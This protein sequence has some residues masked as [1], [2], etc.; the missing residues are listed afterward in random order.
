MATYIYSLSSSHSLSLSL[1]LSLLFSLSFSLPF[2]RPNFIRFSETQRHCCVSSLSH[3]L[4]PPCL[5]FSL[6]TYSVL[7]FLFFSLFLYP[8]LPLIRDSYYLPTLLT[9]SP[10][11]T[12]CF[13]RKGLLV[14]FFFDFI[15]IYIYFFRFSC[16]FYICFL[17]ITS[18]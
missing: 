16:V 18:V 13:A 5:S 11:V 12:S 10:D 8:H 6:L 9:L 14:F 7:S 3:L 17:L 1:S 15:L 4:L 2:C